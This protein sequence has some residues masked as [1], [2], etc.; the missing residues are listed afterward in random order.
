MKKRFILITLPWFQI[1]HVTSSVHGLAIP[2]NSSET[3]YRGISWIWP[4]HI[5]QTELVEGELVTDPETGE[6]SV[7]EDR[8]LSSLEFLTPI[9]LDFSQN[10]GTPPR[11]DIENP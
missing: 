9:C 2:F 7:R 8:V 10:I 1:R 6:N 4:E 11:L 3:D 5:Y